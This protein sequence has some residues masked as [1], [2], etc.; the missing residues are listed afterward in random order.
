MTIGYLREQLCLVQREGPLDLEPSVKQWPG[1]EITQELPR[2][3]S[4]RFL[5]IVCCVSQADLSY[6]SG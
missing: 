1:N 3:G 2:V 6:S 4:I 5:A